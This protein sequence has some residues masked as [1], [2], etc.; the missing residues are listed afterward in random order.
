M[1]T[2]KNFVHKIFLSLLSFSIENTIFAIRKLSMI[3][4][5]DIEKIFDACRIEEVVGDFV[6]LTKHGADYVGLCPFHNDRH[7]SM[8]VSPSKG[9]FKCFV[10]GEGGNAAQFVMK[11]E[12]YSYPEALRYLAK[13]YGINIQEEVRTAEQEEQ[14][15]EESALLSLHE[16]SKNFFVDKLF[17]HS[18]GQDIALTY[19][20]NRGLTDPTIKKFQLGYATSE[21]DALA[22]DA[23]RHGYLQ[24]TIAKSGLAFKK[25][26]GSFNDKFRERVMFP[27]HNYSGKVIAFGGRVMTTGKTE[28]NAKYINSPETAIYHKSNSLYG[29]YFAKNAMSKADKCYLV[30]GYMD[31]ISMHQ[32]GIENVVASSGTALTSGQIKLIKKLTNNITVIYDGDTAGVKAAMRGISLILKE[33]MNVRLVLLPPDEDPDSFAMSHSLEQMQNY[34]SDNEVSF[35][36]FKARLLLKDAKNDPIKKANILSDIAEDVAM[37]D[38]LLVRA[39]FITHCS[40]LLN[41]EESAFAYAVK[42]K[43]RQIQEAKRKEREQAAIE[44]NTIL[45]TY[46]DEPI[47]KRPRELLSQP[48]NVLE[49]AE[50]ELL[51]LL[52]NKGDKLVYFDEKDDRGRQKSLRLDKFIINDLSKDNLTFSNDTYRALFNAYLEELNLHPKSICKHLQINENQQIRDLANALNDLRPKESPGW[53]DK[54]AVINTIDNNEAKL[55]EEAIRILQLIRLEWVKKKRQACLE[56][57]KLPENQNNEDLIIQFNHLN[58]LIYKIEKVLGTSYRAK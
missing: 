43:R 55:L 57:M 4:R 25:A 28:N 33:G 10:C 47:V 1:L 31:V 17:H 14:Y 22:Q 50:H 20:R 5:E 56:Q 27:I 48:I 44:D 36:E 19:F 16:F 35:I 46:D 9:I 34:L 8:H 37:I 12:K 49:N 45:Q 26:D 29:L 54:H 38:E 52:I 7:P 39:E 13:K 3:K 24:D 23:I 40:N 21:K 15:K 53:K 11:H 2:K 32:L 51:K 42:K 30:E 58:K 18:E 6:K 41:I